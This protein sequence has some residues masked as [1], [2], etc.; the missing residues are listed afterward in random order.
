MAM[1]V[2]RDS[3]YK[4]M[5]KNAF[6]DKYGKFSLGAE[7]RFEMAVDLCTVIRVHGGE[8]E[9]EGL[10]VVSEKQLKLPKETELIIPPKTEAPSE[11]RPEAEAK[12]KHKT[13]RKTTPKV[14]RGTATSKDL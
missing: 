11:A 6:W 10:V 2:N 14:R 5:D 13:S 12:P 9:P 4:V 1:G 3:T 7:E 8:I